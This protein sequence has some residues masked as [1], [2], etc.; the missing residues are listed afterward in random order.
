RII[1][2]N[3]PE[4]PNK[5]RYIEILVPISMA[6]SVEQQNVCDDDGYVVDLT[7]SNVEIREEPYRWT[8]DTKIEPYLE[9]S[10]KH[11]CSR[12]R[13]VPNGTYFIYR[14]TG[15]NWSAAL[16]T[17]QSRY[18]EKNN[19]RKRFF[20]K[21]IGSNWFNYRYTGVETKKL[22]NSTCYTDRAKSTYNVKSDYMLF[23]IDTKNAQSGL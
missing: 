19:R 16:G 11:L 23:S 4:V 12:K 15:G 7:L 5:N 20:F 18:N 8:Y 3:D 1:F 13:I 2:S 21:V 17:S 10:G 6:I 9:Q 22:K 14:Y